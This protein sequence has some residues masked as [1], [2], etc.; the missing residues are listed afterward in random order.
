MSNLALTYGNQGRWGE[1]EELQVQVMETRKTKPGPDH[2]DML[3]TMN[4]LASRTGMLRSMCDLA[5]TWEDQG[6][7]LDALALMEEVAQGMQRVLG[8]DDVGT[9]IALATVAKWRRLSLTMQVRT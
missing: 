3:T 7:H 4:N 5:V 6:R 1:A 8:A 2:P 9:R